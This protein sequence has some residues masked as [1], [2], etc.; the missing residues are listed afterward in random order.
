MSDAALERSR[1]LWNRTRLA[2]DSDE[3]L[4]QILDRGEMDAWRALYGLARDDADLRRR[5]KKIVLAVPLP[6]PRL[7][8]AALGSLG[9]EVDLGVTLPSYDEGT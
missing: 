6:L 5:I 3:V 2:L 9:E 1:A 7:W 8:L 4:A